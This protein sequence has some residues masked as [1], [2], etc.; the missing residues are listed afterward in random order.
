M[1]YS[2]YEPLD[3]LRKQIRLLSIHSSE[4]ESSTISCTLQLASLEDQPN[5]NA[6]SYVWGDPNLTQEIVVECEVFKATTNLVSAL[7]HIRGILHQISN[8]ED[9]TS[10]THKAAS[11]QSLALFP[12]STPN[13][14]WIDAICIN[15]DDMTERSSQVQLMGQLFR[16]ARL[17]LGWLGADDERNLGQAVSD[18][19]E[20]S[21]QWQVPGNSL[22]EI[23]GYI[24]THTAADVFQGLDP[25]SRFWQTL[26]HDEQLIH[27][28]W[29]SVFK[30]FD[31]GY[32]KRVWIQQEIIM[33]KNLVFLL[34]YRSISWESISRFWSQIWFCTLRGLIPPDI[35]SELWR[36]LLDDCGWASSQVFLF[37]MKK[38]EMAR[39]GPDIL[40]DLRAC[41]AGATDPRD[42]V[43]G[44]LGFQPVSMN[45]DYNASV[46]DVFVQFW[47][48]CLKTQQKDR[49]FRSV[50]RNAGSGIAGRNLSPHDLPSWVE[51]FS[52]TCITAQGILAN[53]SNGLF[54][55]VGNEI[56]ITPSGILKISG[57]MVDTVEDVR[58]P[59]VD[60]SSQHPSKETMYVEF[61][62]YIMEA[63]RY[64][65]G[66]TFDRDV[67]ALEAILRVVLDDEGPP[68]DGESTRLNLG[69]LLTSHIVVISIYQLCVG[70]TNSDIEE[71]FGVLHVDPGPNFITT[72][73]TAFP[74]MT[75][76]IPATWH[77]GMTA[78]E[79][80]RDMEGTSLGACTNWTA[81]RLNQ[82]GIS[83]YRFFH[84]KNNRLGMG[85]P[86]MR[87]GDLIYVWPV[88][89][90]LCIVRTLENGSKVYV[91]PAFVL[92][93]SHG[94]A[95]ELVTSG[96][97]PVEKLEIH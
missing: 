56:D 4:D 77:A 66:H 19:Q 84:T 95:A 42:H 96:D 79:V 9:S 24:E 69:S 67:P 97:Y 6:L 80:V 91:G 59:V 65:R 58:I 87:S 33:A 10:G 52:R 20:V 3:A 63:A 61:A 40:L 32:W 5:F 12:R 17:A 93:L 36:F 30:I 74:S 49:T 81:H 27:P 76:T 92:G 22:D 57:I 82:K 60:S 48:K 86:G 16:S 78:L 85:P 94:E 64:Y 55:S 14:F 38:A 71:R 29:A 73:N 7:R 35:P 90:D 39:N 75:D 45:V 18:L 46:R 44:T 8:N 72:L 88:S 89:V 13:V 31:L 43:F 50:F 54:P 26:D 51:D 11:S 28:L 68:L 25:F 62:M 41:R 37:A 15:Q 53:A 34:G 1:S 21:N 83:G 2:F 70:P 23:C 47:E